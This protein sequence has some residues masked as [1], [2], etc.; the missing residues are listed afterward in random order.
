MITR[1]ASTKDE[2]TYARVSTGHRCHEGGMGLEG[3]KAVIRPAMRSDTFGTDL[4]LIN[5][6]GHRFN[7][8]L[9]L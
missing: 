1:K 3:R 5:S 2:K 8:I 4:T 9:A 6:S 7:L